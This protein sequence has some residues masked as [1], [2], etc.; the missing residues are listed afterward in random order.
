MRVKFSGFRSVM[1]RPL[2]ERR[3]SAAFALAL[4][5]KKAALDT[6]TDVD[7]V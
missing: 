4:S 1:A 2:A 7:I 6:Q 3:R 5:V